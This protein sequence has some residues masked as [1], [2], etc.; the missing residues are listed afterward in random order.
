[1]GFFPLYSSMKRDINTNS[2]KLELLYVHDES[3]R[4]KGIT[5]YYIDKLKR[6]AIDVGVECIYVVA[7]VSVD[8]FSKDKKGNAL[9]QNDLEE[10]YKRK[11]SPEMPIIIMDK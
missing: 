11:S 4:R 8:N 6:L 1:M 7:N 2:I 5:G 3:L 10:Y 9:S